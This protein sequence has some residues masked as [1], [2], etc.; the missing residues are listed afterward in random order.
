VALFLLEEGLGPSEDF[1]FA[2]LEAWG[3]GA[4][5]ADFFLMGFLAAFPLRLVQNLLRRFLRVN[6]V[7]SGSQVPDD[8]YRDGWRGGKATHTAFIFAC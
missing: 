5:L 8:G 1:L 4:E 6:V 7:E 3:E 2:F